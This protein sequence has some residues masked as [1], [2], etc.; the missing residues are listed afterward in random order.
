V[1]AQIIVASS[2]PYFAEVLRSSLAEAGDQVVLPAGSVDEALALAAG[3]E[4]DLLVLDAS[5]P[6]ALPVDLPERLSALS[7]LPRLLVIM[8]KGDAALALQDQ[9]PAEAELFPFG[10]LAALPDTVRKT[11]ETGQ[12]RAEAPADSDE[13][14]FAGLDELA[15][16]NQFEALL[17]A[18]AGELLAH[19]RGVSIEE[20]ET[21]VQVLSEHAGSGQRGDLARFVRLPGKGNL[22]LYATSVGE[23]LAAGVADETL[24]M[25]QVRSR[26]AAIKPELLRYF[27]EDLPPGWAREGEQAEMGMPELTET[28]NQPV[29]EEEIAPI[30][31]D[32]LFSE[33][34]GPNPDP[35]AAD[36]EWTRTAEDEPQPAGKPTD[37]VSDTRPVAAR[38]PAA[39]EALV[40]PWDHLPPG[41][42]TRPVPADHGEQVVRESQ[43]PSAPA[44]ASITV[45]LVPDYPRHFLIGEL[46][47]QL[48]TWAA[49]RCKEL[50]YTLNGLVVRREYLQCTLKAPGNPA[51][52]RVAAQL[53][54][55]L[56]Q[57]V[58]THYPHWRVPGDRNFWASEVLTAPGDSPPSQAQIWDFIHRLRRKQGFYTG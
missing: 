48:S 49:R 58:F 6:Q 54:R 39:E 26:M 46:G 36:D 10:S 17:L 9:L 52:D 23:A 4:I 31:L 42:A 29:E 51:P 25:A 56:S 38:P 21:L 28:Y 18:R 34:T 35:P 41:E 40:L 7:A 12:P 3:V 20:A 30:S 57:D 15:Q 53:S 24:T 11:L 14:Q 5:H 2:H 1:P 33:E 32:E 27:L 45:V 19:S 16:A 43:R 13:G 55:R 47:D 50:G 37:R 8:P 22:L 44:L